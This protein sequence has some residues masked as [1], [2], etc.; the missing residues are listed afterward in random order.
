MR[1]WL[2]PL[3]L[4]VL[5]IA[6]VAYVVVGSQT[7]KPTAAAPGT[8]SPADLASWARSGV[9]TA[10]SVKW[11][12]ETKRSSSTTATRRT[13]WTKAARSGSRTRASGI[14]TRLFQTSTVSF[15]ERGLDVG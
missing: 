12:Q 11:T 13:Y 2:A 10:W 7:A 5:A 4:G 9:A 15:T 8:S 14:P 6:V 1:A 3:V